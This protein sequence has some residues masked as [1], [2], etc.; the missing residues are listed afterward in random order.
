[1]EC[2]HGTL[3]SSVQACCAVQLV[4]MSLIVGALRHRQCAFVSKHHIEGHKSF[5]FVPFVHGSYPGVQLAPVAHQLNAYAV[6]NKFL[7]F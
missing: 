7:C 5:F 4:A 6:F 3:M 1:M 2:E